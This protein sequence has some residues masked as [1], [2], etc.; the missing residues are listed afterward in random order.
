MKIHPR[1]LKRIS[2]KTT[3]NRARLAMPVV[4]RGVMDI[5][6][7]K[8]PQTISV[9][10]RVDLK[11]GNLNF[12]GLRK[13]FALFGDFLI[14]FKK[15]AA[16]TLVLA[17]ILQGGGMVLLKTTLAYF[18]DNE[19]SKNNL[20]TATNLDFTSS[21]VDFAPDLTTLATSTA[22]ATLQ[23]IGAL[24]F[25]YIAHTGTT[26]GDGDFCGAI[27][28]G[29]SLGTDLKYSGLINNFTSTTT[30]FSLASSTWNL[31][32]NLAQEFLT[33]KTCQFK[34]VFTGW[35]DNLPTFGGFNDT[36]EV[37]FEIKYKAPQLV[38]I[39]KVYANPDDLHSSDSSHKN[40]WVELINTGGE[41]IDITN[42]KIGN[43]NDVDVLSS[44]TPL[45]IP[46][47]G[48]AIITGQS[49]TYKYW[50]IPSGVLLITLSD[51]KIG[52]GLNDNKDLII[53]KDN[54]DRVIDWMDWGSEPAGLPWDEKYGV[55]FWEHG[56]I[57]A[58]EGNMLSR[59]PNGFD[60][61]SVSD[62]QELSP[63]SV[64]MVYPT[65]GEVWYVGHTYDIKWTAHNNNS[66]T[67]DSLLKISLFYSNDSGHTW[68]EFAHEI[69]NTGSYNWHVPLYIGGYYV[70][71]PI[72]RIKVVATG[73]ENFMMQNY[74][75]SRDFCPPIDYDALSPEDQSLV[76]QLVA[77]GLIDLREVIK[78]GV[79][80]APE[81]PLPDERQDVATETPAEE[82]SQGSGG[83]SSDITSE[84]PQA[85]GETLKDE[86][87]SS[88]E[89]N[90]L[91]AAIEEESGA[92][93]TENQEPLA[94]E[95][96][97]TNPDS[98]QNSE[99]QASKGQVSA[100]PALLPKDDQTPAVR[101]VIAPQPEDADKILPDPI[102]SEPTDM[103]EQGGAE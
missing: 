102:I 39:N 26:G 53:L 9:I 54:N 51:G 31:T 75:S 10:R 59:V 68:A 23:N 78:G 74:A 25:K 13:K 2:R 96:E 56:V 12:E 47:G 72:A 70:P 40:E 46:A 16:T 34:M 98:A 15:L 8:R 3:Y 81:E 30:N 20:F 57:A 83:A 4:L 18:K 91:G 11:F 77:Q 93:E 44:T 7:V 5:G 95:N 38:K 35:Q 60:T 86:N 65:G 17:I 67:A 52:N 100:N 22:S 82:F 21:R 99:E 58:E 90:I 41:P 24:N 36:E 62:W 48:Y 28:L 85:E 43:I 89:E 92:S 6:V 61:D 84:E 63:P 49:S 33:D 42:W 88:G 27:N 97:T 64:T 101:E 45:I 55:N 76:D 50:Q 73:P 19:G 87:I 79:P 94:V 71:S 14:G 80:L 103:P 37:N 66:T 69:G 1:K 29:A 32:A